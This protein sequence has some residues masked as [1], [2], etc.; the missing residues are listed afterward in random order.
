MSSL[1]RD[2]KKNKDPPIYGRYELCRMTNGNQNMK[3][4]LSAAQNTSV[5]KRKNK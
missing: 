4:L 3:T 1:S 5:Q 2:G